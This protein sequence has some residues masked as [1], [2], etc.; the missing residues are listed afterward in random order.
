M[1]EVF[2]IG[3]VLA[4]ALPTIFGVIPAAIGGGTF[5]LLNTIY[6][7]ALWWL[8]RGL[9]N[10]VVATRLRGGILWAINRDTGELDV[11]RY[12]PVSGMIHTPEASYNLI[13][14][15]VLNV[16][17]VPIG[18]AP[19]HTGYNVGI[20]EALL[21]DELK[22][23]GINSIRDICDVDPYGRF[24]NFNNDERI[25]DLRDK[26]Y[27]IKTG[28]EEAG[29]IFYIK[30]WPINLD[31]FHHYTSKAANPVF[32]KANIKYGIW[33]GLFGQGGSGWKWAIGIG[34]AICI[35]LLIFILIR[36]GGG[37]TSENIRYIVDNAGR[38]VQV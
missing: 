11:K 38:I 21:L 1:K 25:K 22:A 24:L 4:I 26:Y 16:D 32:Q 27:N 13:K 30:P 29:G 34:L 14:N 35:G 5:I 28:K 8:M 7:V 9:P 20:N 10:E 36:G 6:L 3:L 33:Q 31:G 15:R 19:E 23:R 37:S 2:V 18:I 12:V 17:G